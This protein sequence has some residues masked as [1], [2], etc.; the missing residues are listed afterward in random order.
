MHGAGVTAVV[1]GLGEKGGAVSAVSGGS[2]VKPLVTAAAAGYTELTEAFCLGDHG[3][4]GSPRSSASTVAECAAQCSAT[5]CYGFEWACGGH[6][7][8][9]CIVFASS[10]DCGRLQRSGCGSDT[11]INASNPTPPVQPP[12]PAPPPTPPPPVRPSYDVSLFE[13]ELLP[14]W[15]AQYALPSPGEFSIS[16]NG[17][18]PHPYATSDVAHVLC[19]TG[20]LGNLSEAD[21]DQWAAV[22][23]KFQRDDGFYNNTDV[24]GVSGGTLWHAAGYVPAGLTLLGR[25]PLRRNS[26]LD[27]IAATPSEWEPTVSALLNVNADPSIPNNISSGC[28]DG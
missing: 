16:P 22:I 25:S 15:M 20:Q 18:V 17:S 12:S 23:N 27:Q 5:G 21:R 13:T 14:K 2:G 8:I 6:K 10:S 3:G 19:F 9:P 11:Y 1:L 4:G 7:G 28:S 26:L 24:D